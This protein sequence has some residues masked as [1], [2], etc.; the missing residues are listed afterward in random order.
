M[1]LEATKYQKERGME[2]K[3]STS[4]LQVSNKEKHLKTFKCS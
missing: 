1:N 2:Q 3:S 4:F